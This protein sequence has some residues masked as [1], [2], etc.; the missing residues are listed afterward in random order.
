MKAWAPKNLK[1]DPCFKDPDPQ[2]PNCKCTG[3]GWWSH[4][5]LRLQLLIEC[6]VYPQI[7]VALPVPLLLNGRDVAN[8]SFIDLPHSFCFCITFYQAQVIKP[9]IVIVW[10]CL[11]RQ[12]SWIKTKPRATLA[13]L[14]ELKERTRIS[15][16]LQCFSGSCMFSFKNTIPENL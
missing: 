1:W 10:I 5:Y 14:C 9:C 13:G 15:I 7:D 12:I 6:V 4:S 2:E 11:K 16:F 3:C 8:G